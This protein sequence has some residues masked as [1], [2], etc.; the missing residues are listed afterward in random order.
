MDQSID[1]Y[2]GLSMFME[3][4][5]DNLTWR[6]N[7]TCC[8][9]ALGT[10][11]FIPASSQSLFASTEDAG[12]SVC[13]TSSSLFSFS[14]ICILFF[15][16]VCSRRSWEFLMLNHKQK[17]VNPASFYLPVTLA[18]QIIPSRVLIPRHPQNR[19]TLYKLAPIRGG[20]IQN[21]HST[22]I[23]VLL[24]ILTLRRFI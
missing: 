5:E 18:S 23:K 8:S 6:P 13:S 14:K 10:Q 22:W 11:M 7:P 3:R 17:M 9:F 12:C 15:N 20:Q 4:P 16:W 24:I 21:P 19:A 1:S 2:I